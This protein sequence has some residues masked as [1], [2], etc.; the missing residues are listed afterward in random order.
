MRSSLTV[1]AVAAAALML[2][3][4]GLLAV[5]TPAGAT[6]YQTTGS[7]S[8]TVSPTG[9]GSP[10]TSVT[11][12]LQN[13]DTMTV[14]AS[15]DGA[16]IYADSTETL[17][18]RGGTSLMYA[19]NVDTAGN[20]LALGTECANGSGFFSECVG[21]AGQEVPNVGTYTFTFSKPVSNPIF[22]FGGIG[23]YYSAAIWSDLT[24]TTP[25]MSMTLLNSN[26]NL[27][28]D[29]GTYLHT[30]NTTSQIN[31]S[32]GV[33]A[34]CGSVQV[35][36]SGTTF[37]F[38]AGYASDPAL[39]SNSLSY[40]GMD[41]FDV[42]VSINTLD[43]VFYSAGSESFSSPVPPSTP[44]ADGSSVTLPTP[45]P[46]TVGDVFAGW[47]CDNSG[48][49]VVTTAT[50]AAGGTVCTAQWAAPLYTVTYNVGAGSNGPSPV[51]GLTYNTNQTLDSGAG[52]TPPAGSTFA[53]WDCG[54]GVVTSVT[55]TSNV[56]CTATYAPIHYTV[57]YNPG[58]GSG[59]V[60]PV[61]GLASGSTV[62]VAS[63]AGLTP[64]PGQVFAGWNCG[65]GVV[66]SVTVTSNITCT[67]FYKSD[68]VNVNVTFDANF[69]SKYGTGRAPASHTAAVGSSFTV[70]GN[71]SH[72][73]VPGYVFL[74]WST[75]AKSQAG[76]TGN[77]L[78]VGA[79]GLTLYAVWA[80]VT[81]L[82]VVHY[83]VNQ[84]GTNF[85]NYQ[86]VVNHVAKEIVAGHYMTITIAASA[87][88]R[89]P[90]G[91]NG[92]LSVLR[93]GAARTALVAAL[94]RLG[95]THVRFIIVNEGVSKTY[96]SYVANRHAIFSGFPG[97]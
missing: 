25:G 59:S 60:S 28:V 9:Y 30:V 37:T 84:W 94:A 69:P 35:N 47:A 70:P 62:N 96:P 97:K 5:A 46:S 49:S 85:P 22:S 88:E 86:A 36:G 44:G 14:S 43:S 3:V 93:S 42:S 78:T 1:K 77:H 92:T 26:G 8:P 64:P 21:K 68:V 29:G 72:L 76:H 50:I 23:G 10:N 17:A 66:T 91:W 80:P 16:T 18:T 83:F 58:A 20:A 73:E 34:G 7:Y 12:T 6:T 95:D 40:G 74:G 52:V 31:C 75:N 13:G 79:K 24:L 33:V 19:P 89:G 45:G 61:T 41:I 82:G 4:V 38:T 71:S 54:S 39:P 55:V 11:T 90:L 2:N 56:T 63:G 51:T 81:Q 67:A 32:T 27:A 48:S 87:D 15:G 53:G 57:T 65:S